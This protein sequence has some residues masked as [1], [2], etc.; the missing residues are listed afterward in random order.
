MDLNRV[1][2]EARKLLLQNTVGTNPC[3]VL[4]SNGV[5]SNSI[6][7]SLIE[8][9]RAPFVFSFRVKGYESK[10]WRMAKI[11]ARALDLRFID[12]ELPTNVDDIFKDVHWAVKKMGLT[13]KTD[14]ECSIPMKYA[15]DRAI[16]L[17]IADVYSGL[18]ADGHYALTRK[19]FIEVRNN[20]KEND[21]AWLE[22]YRLK[23]FS[24][25]NPDQSSTMTDYFKSKK[26]VFHVPYLD[27]G[28][29]SIFKGISHNEMNRPKQKMPIR[30]VFPELE[31]WGVGNR[32][33]N[34]QLGDSGIADNY[35]RLV[36]SEYNSHNYKSVVGIYNSVV[37]G[38][39]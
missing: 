13:K 39:F 15:L 25:E 18:C 34:L 1:G 23:C 12:V 7:A 2:A 8:N 24:K 38:E 35:S 11:T 5:D 32:R 21:P 14:I 4:L 29:F 28:F 20:E 3:G 22:N 6:L 36:T 16:Q 9:G 19:A 30:L 17:G 10:D 31:Q 33:V 26:G 27:V 37:R